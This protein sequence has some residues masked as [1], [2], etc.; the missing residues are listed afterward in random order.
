MLFKSAASAKQLLIWIFVL[1]LKVISDLKVYIIPP[2]YIMHTYIDIAL[3]IFDRK[4]PYFVFDVKFL[5]EMHKY[6]HTMKPEN[7]D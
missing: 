1:G 5:M 6:M 2:N 7:N 4:Y 3:N